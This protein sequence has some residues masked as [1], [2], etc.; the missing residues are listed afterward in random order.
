M[1]A[2]PELF[3]GALGLAVFLFLNAVIARTT[4]Y[5]AQVPFDSSSIWGSSVFQTAASILWTLTALGAMVFAARKASHPRRY[6]R[7]SAAPQVNPAPKAAKQI[8]SP[9]PICPS[10]RHSWKASGM[11]AAVVL[12]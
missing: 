10:A 6:I 1:K 9:G 7:Y 4:H 3:F 2:L 12:P 5:W 8:K 11:L